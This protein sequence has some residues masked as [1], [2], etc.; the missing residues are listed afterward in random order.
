MTRLPLY[1]ALLAAL[2]LA[3]LLPNHYF[4]WLS[5]WHE[6]LALALLLGAAC[7]ARGPAL[8]PWPWALT[9]ALAL[10]SALLQWSSGRIF[11]GGDALMVGLYVGAFLLAL[12]LGSQLVGSPGTNELPL[13]ALA[14]VTLCCALVS[15][16]LAL[17]QWTNALSLGL[18]GTD[19]P[20]GAR[21]GANVS[22]PNHFC[23]LAFLGLCSLGLLRE[24]GR[25]TGVALLL[26]ALFL[27]MGMVMSA[28]RTGWL[29]AALLLL[30]VAAAGRRVRTRI[31]WPQVTGWVMVYALATLAW[32]W[33]N[34]VLLLSGGRGVAE[35]IEGGARGPLWLA[36]L[37]AVSRHPWAGWGWQ[38]VSWAQFTV[39]PDH[40]PIQRYFEHSHNLVLDL[41][42]WAGLPVGGLIVV[43]AATALWRQWRGLCD[44]RGL[45][46]LAGALGVVVHAMLE[47]PLEYAYF[48][49]PVGVALGA[50]HALGP[51][52]RGL[53][54]SR[55]VLQAVGA[56]GLTCFAAV[57]V[58][59]LQAEQNH[60]LLRLE[61]A[62]IGT[63]GIETPAVQ[64][65]LLT[66]LSAFLAYAREEARPGLN[67]VEMERA[68]QVA[69]RFA[70]PP[71][72]FRF[73][74]I[75]A[76]NGQPEKAQQTLVRICYM[77]L[78]ARC[79]EA[80][81]AWLALRQ[82]YPQLPPMPNL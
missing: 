76:L 80:R 78:P 3:W 23:T 29:Q 45:W 15:V 18:Y 69:Q 35:Q 57:A 66:Q 62:G 4:P 16:G 65:R 50:G 22:Q 1:A 79:D 17:V 31:R 26:S 5:A 58:E 61:T 47:F 59:Y 12:A 43:L 64:L 21:P 81:E 7:A 55:R 30:L 42:L 36:L 27:L 44:A 72:M 48:L 49:L 33:L 39:A 40:A 34:R 68:E 28:S 73:A 37:D 41:L 8:L 46:L 20:P 32:P 53:W 71:V 24:R 38:Q 60:R 2:P 75:A 10:A 51:A 13:D 67:A 77:H 82:R 56:V 6:G 74:L 63:R 14:F 70:Y 52:G 11:F 9:G 19:L 54:L 25:V